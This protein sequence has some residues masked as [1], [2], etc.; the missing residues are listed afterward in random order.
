MLPSQLAG[1]L[2]LG[3]VWGIHEVAVARKVAVQA[4][5]MTIS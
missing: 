5:R 2:W 3:R 1:Y 4:K